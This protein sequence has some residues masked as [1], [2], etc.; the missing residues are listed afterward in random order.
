MTEEE[1]NT[2]SFV[3]DCYVDLIEY[4]DCLYNEYNIKKLPLTILFRNGD[5]ESQS[6]SGQIVVE[7][8]LPGSK[9]RVTVKMRFN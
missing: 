7:A 1:N 3:K 5:L 4:L 8:K 2:N 6:V 9:P